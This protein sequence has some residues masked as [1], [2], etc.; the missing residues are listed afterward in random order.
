MNAP[1]ASIAPSHFEFLRDP[2]AGLEGIGVLHASAWRERT[3]THCQFSADPFVAGRRV[4]ALPE[5]TEGHAFTLELD[6]TW[7]LDGHRA[8]AREGLGFFLDRSFRQ[9]QADFEKLLET[10]LDTGVRWDQRDRGGCSRRSASSGRRACCG[11]CSTAWP[12]RRAN[13]RIRG[14]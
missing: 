8:F 14:T 9:D 2:A 11:G 4:P 12:H 5:V 3:P 1:L 13:R 6:R 7:V 10:D